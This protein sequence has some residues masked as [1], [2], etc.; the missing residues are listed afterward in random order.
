MKS[1]RLII[2]ILSIVLCLVVVFQ[3]C[4]TGIVNGI[5][6]NTTDTSAGGGIILAFVFLV[7]GISAIVTRDKKAGSII[8]GV[9]Y[10]LGGLIGMGNKGTFGDLQ[11]WSVLSLVF[12]ALFII[13]ALFM[14][15][16]GA[17]K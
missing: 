3:S 4:A 16:K 10:L 13:P 11:V 15:K 5:E 1:L 6:E 12:A 9:I 7:A 8:T 17:D 2:G 14:K